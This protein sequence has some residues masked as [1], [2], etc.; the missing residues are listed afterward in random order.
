VGLDADLDDGLLTGHGHPVGTVR[1]RRRRRGVDRRPPLQ[2]MRQRPAAPPT[3]FY[4]DVAAFVTGFLA[5]VYAHEWSEQDTGWRWCAQWC[6]H[7][8][9]LVRLEALWKAW[10]VLRLDPGTG[11]STWLRDHADPA[12]HTLTSPAGPFA[13]CTP[14]RHTAPPALVTATPPHGLFASSPQ[15]IAS[16]PT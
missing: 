11:A 12:M 4:P 14:V 6:S 16:K 8:E 3:N 10:E 9:A 1:P 13:R 15:A 2:R 5:G 7:T